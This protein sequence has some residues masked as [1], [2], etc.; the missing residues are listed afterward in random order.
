MGL[1]TSD[2]IRLFLQQ[3]VNIGG[4]PFQ[5]TAKKPNAET[6]RAIKNAATGKNLSKYKDVD[7]LFASWDGEL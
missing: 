1:K 6:L 5:P 3:C 7:S 2:A 4:L